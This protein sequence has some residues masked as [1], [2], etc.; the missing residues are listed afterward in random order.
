MKNFVIIFLVNIFTLLCSA[1]DSQQRNLLTG[2]TGIADI[3]E[4]LQ[5]AVH[6]HPYPTIDEPEAWDSYPEF[7]RTAF[8]QQGEKYFDYTW[9]VIPATAALDFVRD[10]NRTN[11]ENVS[12][13][14]RQA[15]TS[16]VMAELFERQGRFTDQIVNGIWAI[17]EETYWGVSA[18]IGYQERGSG[19]PD[20]TEPTIDLF[21]AETSCQLAWTLYL[22]GSRLDEIS[23]LIR[24]RIEYEIQRRILEPGLKRTDFW[25]MGYDEQ[26]LNNWTPWICSNWLPSVMLIEKDPERKAES[27][28]KIMT[29]L[30]HFLN[31]YPADGGCDEGPGYWN[32]AGGALFDCLDNLY[33]ISGGKID[34]FNEQLIIN[35]GLYIHRVY[36]SYPYFINFADAS[37]TPDPDPFLIY[38]YGK[39]INSKELMNFGSFLGVKEWSGPENLFYSFGALGRRQLPA[40][41][42]FNDVLKYD[43]GESFELFNW[44]PDIQVMTARSSKASTDGLFLAAKGG[45]NNESHNHNDVGN[46]IVYLNGKPAII[47]VGVETYRRQTFS[48]ERYTIW[49]MQ[50]AYH[51]LPTI[52]GQMQMNGRQYEARNVTFEKSKYGIQFGLNLEHAYTDE[53][54]VKSYRRTIDFKG[55]KEILLKDQYMF[56]SSISRVDLNIMTCFGIDEN[57]PGQLVLYNKSNPSDRL[58]LTYNKEVLTLDIEPIPITDNRLKSVWGDEI[59]RLIFRASICPSNFGYLVKLV[60]VN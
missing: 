35:M 7:I 27:V 28:Y 55:G 31:K 11:W 16:L 6:W 14:R 57:K 56:D 15:L 53:A 12:F 24:E 52:N 8:I 44:L 39:R 51:N 42:I 49:T 60:E 20:V 43:A 45:H 37:A 19:L 47:D 1:Q 21:A 22:L 40:L 2:K 46:F 58:K 3:S 13:R 26:S 30:D 4:M 29:I 10:G 9:P 50:S 54:G 25:W 38:R 23:P 34:L 48:N 33:S 36:I 5:Q 41:M 32:E 59:T 18:H 17:C